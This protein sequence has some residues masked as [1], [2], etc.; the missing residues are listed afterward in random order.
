MLN[1]QEL[2]KLLQHI[3]ILYVED[4]PLTQEEMYKILSLFSH[5]IFLASN[6][7]EALKIYEENKIQLIISDIEMPCMNGIKFIEKIR[8]KDLIIPI[9]MMTA[10][11]ENDY[12]ISCTN[13]GVQGYIIKPINSTKLKNALY[14]ATEYLNLTSNLLIKINTNLVY[15]KNNSLLIEDNISQPLNKKEKALLDLLMDNKNKVV[16][17]EQIEQKVWYD[18]DEV[19]TPT[20]LRTVIKNLR[21][22]SSSEFI[23]NSSGLGYKLIVATPHS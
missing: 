21:K 13:L 5:H 19:M 20:A 1:S 10:H 9:I 16:P 7:T 22:K 11:S 18:Y 15:D 17:Y 3:T 23:A 2:S 6:G 8:E 4:D 12:L 14:K